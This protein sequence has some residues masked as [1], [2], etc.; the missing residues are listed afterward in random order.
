MSTRL[1]LA[2]PATA[3]LWRRIDRAV[4]DA[5][6]QGR[7]KPGDRLPSVADLAGDLKVARLTVLKAFRG[8]EKEGLLST[9]VGRGTFVSG[10]VAGGAPRGASDARPD[11]AAALRRLREGYA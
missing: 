11:V 1:R 9:E 10:G 8:L 5:V 2:G 3:P 4:R 7:L 6:E